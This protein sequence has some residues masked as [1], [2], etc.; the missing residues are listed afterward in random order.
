[1]NGAAIQIVV[2]LIAQIVESVLPS[3]ASD[4][5]TQ[6]VTTIINTLEKLLPDIISAGAELSTSVKN[7]IAALQGNDEIS[8]EQWDQL[9][10]FEKQIDAEFD[11][12]AKDEGF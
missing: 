2:A 8:Q 3:L 6:L 7:I 12:A 5:T 11:Q 1:M 9:D 10:V 4:K